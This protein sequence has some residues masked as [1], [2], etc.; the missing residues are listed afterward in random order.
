[1]ILTVTHVNEP[2]VWA[3]NPASVSYEENDTSVVATYLATDPERGVVRYSLVG[4]DDAA[5]DNDKFSIGSLD[6]KLSF[7]SS[8]NFEKPGD[9]GTNANNTYQVTVQAEVVEANPLPPS[10]PAI[11]PAHTTTQPVTVMVTNVNEE[12]VFTK[13]LEV[14]Q[15]SENADDPEK[16]PPATATYLYLLNRGVGKPATNRPVTPNLDLGVPVVAVDD[17]STSTF[18][19]GG[20]ETGTTVTDRIDG[21][22]YELSGD[23]EPFHIVPATGQILTREKLDYEAKNEYVI[24][25]T[26]TDPQGESDSIDLK[27]EVINLDERPVPRVLQITAGPSSP[28]YEENGTDAVGEYEVTAYGGATVANPRWSLEG[29]DGGS[30]MLAP[31]GASRM[32]K[33][34]SAPDYE[35]PMGGAND[36]SNTYEVTLKVTDPS[37]TATFGTLRVTVEVTNVDELGAL[38][39]STT[40]VSVNEGDTDALGTY[41]LTAIEDG[42]TVTWSREGVDADQFMLEGTGMSRMLK[43]SSAPDYENPMGGADD[44]SNTYMVTVMASAGGE[45]AMVEVTIMVDQRGGTRYADRR[46]GQP[47]RAT[48]RTAWMTVATYTADGTMAD[49]ATWTKMGADADYFTIMG[50]M[51]KFSSAPDFEAPMGGADNDSNTYMVTVKAEAGGEDGHAGSHRHG[52][53]RGGTRYADRRYGQPHRAPREQHGHRGDLH[54]LRPDGGQCHVDA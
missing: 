42:P 44:D 1:M 25:V 24:T 48:W 22:T 4:T 37:D 28:D 39:G 38:S 45:E 5:A 54:G 17:D 27:I 49:M 41:T 31:T 53:Q 11:P 50:G 23:R 20:Y 6:G 21:L 3:D 7:K 33:F 26:A 14:L 18:A 51:L 43:F 46:Y 47:H 19:I 9:A 32:L 16:E 52:H 8:P 30:F 29:A 13:T 40:N 35:N 10:D 34:R 12:P 2:P 36:D 15:I